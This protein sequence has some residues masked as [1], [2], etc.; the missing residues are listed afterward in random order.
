[1]TAVG[2]AALAPA[3]LRATLALLA[4]YHL[5]IGLVSVASPAGTRRVARAF[6]GL[7]LEPGP[8]V[9]YAVR[10]LG[11]YALALGTL[12]A[13]AAWRPAEHRATVLVLA[14]LQGAR[15]LSRLASARTLAADFGVPPARNRANA[16]LLLAEA[17]VLAFCAPAA[18]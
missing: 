5:A 7:A 14:A 18:R 13:L 16:A 12:V 4:A 10:M 1:V 2:G 9:A 17:A 3:L 11:L 15:A 8:Q 6:Y